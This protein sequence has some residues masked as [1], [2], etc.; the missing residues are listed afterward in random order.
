MRLIC[1][2]NAIVTAA[3]LVFFSWVT[4]G[5]VVS[6][7]GAQYPLID[8]ASIVYLLACS[9]VLFESVRWLRVRS[10]SWLCVVALVVMLL[11]NGVGGYY[12]FASSGDYWVKH[13]S[14]DLVFFSWI[15]MSLVILI[16]RKCDG[17]LKGDS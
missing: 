9:V 2:V 15:L 3:Q 1:W 8:F 17:I 11:H 6:E 16:M 14:I 7:E 10:A 4:V 5:T 13:C 12:C